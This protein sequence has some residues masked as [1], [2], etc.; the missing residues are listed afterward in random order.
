M[1]TALASPSQAFTDSVLAPLINAH[2]NGHLGT[3]LI[4][5][6]KMLFG[7]Q[8]AEAALDQEKEDRKPYQAGMA[9]GGHGQ[10][11]VCTSIVRAHLHLRANGEEANAT[12]LRE[13]ADGHFG[14]QTV[15][16]EMAKVLMGG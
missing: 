8:T 4:D 3:K 9:N 13:I 14:A 6:A 7:D 10:T 5:F 11:G 16:D 2:L 1:P 15:D 12:E